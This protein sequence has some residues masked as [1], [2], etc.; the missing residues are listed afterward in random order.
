MRRRFEVSEKVDYGYVINRQLDRIA[1][2]RSAVYKD[3][4]S[5]IFSEKN[6]KPVN[7]LYDYLFALEAL[8]AILLPELRGD[9]R[10]ILAHVKALAPRVAEFMRNYCGWT[11]DSGT[12]SEWCVQLRE[13]LRPKIESL[14]KR[15]GIRSVH[16]LFALFEL[17]DL[18]LERMLV[19]INDAGL[20]MRSRPVRV[21]AALGARARGAPEQDIGEVTPDDTDGPDT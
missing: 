7:R 1:R 21:G 5:D 13:E 4:D 20:L 18:A 15:Y 16:P 8:H 6:V 3:L 12:T 9:T 19:G 14:R 10:E 17:A 2:V 11:E